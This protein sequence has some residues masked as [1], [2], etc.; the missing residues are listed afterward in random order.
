MLTVLEE[1]FDKFLE[2]EHEFQLFDQVIDGVNFWERIRTPI[3]QTVYRNATG[4]NLLQDESSTMERV[5]GRA[6]YLI[7]SLLGFFRT[8]L[9][10]SQRDILFLCNPRRILRDDGY[11]WD[12]YTDFIIED[13]GMSY[14][15]IEDSSSL[16]HRRP[17]RT[18]GLLDLDLLDFLRYIAEK[19]GLIN[20]SLSAE[21]KKLILNIRL[22]I[23]RRTDVDID[24][25]RMITRRL[26]YRKIWNPFY[27]FILRRIKPKVIVLVTSY[28]KEDFIEAAKSLSIPIIE[29]QHGAI[30]PYHPGY[31]FPGKSK[32]DTFPDLYFAFGDHWKDLADFPIDKNRT[33]SM[34]FPFLDEEM[35]KY[36]DLPKKEQILFISQSSIG[37]KLSKF[38]TTLSKLEHGYKIVFKLHPLE[39]KGWRVKYPWLAEADLDVVDDSKPSLYK[40]F[41]ESKIQI[42]VYSTAIYE[43]LAFGL[44]T[45]L[46]D[47]PGVEY[48]ESLVETG[49]A[50][51]V[52]SVEEF[53]KHIKNNSTFSQ[54]DKEKFFRRGAKERIVH[55]LQRYV[56]RG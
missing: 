4:E 36:A 52:S 51:K 2:L 56:S 31:S 8:P 49:V 10:T 5:R 55:W 39:C 28:N 14:A 25:E 30:S 46:L 18:T 12:I 11:W 15:A 27:R 26:G 13:I 29:L 32:K 35:N 21:E 16:S 42:G 34:G 6:R 22:E 24:I 43:G 50:L 3:I 17:A 20:V 45:Y 1:I 54:F 37:E 23:L 19:L 48:F 9:F 41:S 33:I 44:A 7:S 40:I 53:V 38:A 47:V